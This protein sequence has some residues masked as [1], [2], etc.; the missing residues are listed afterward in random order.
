[1]T[2]TGIAVNACLFREEPFSRSGLILKG[3][4]HYLPLHAGQNKMFAKI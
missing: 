2:V 4:T 1:M 3:K